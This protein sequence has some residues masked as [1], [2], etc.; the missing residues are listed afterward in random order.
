MIQLSIDLVQKSVI[1]IFL[2]IRLFVIFI[3]M[4]ILIKNGKHCQTVTLNC[5]FTDNHADEPLFS[6]HVYLDFVSTGSKPQF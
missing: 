2:Q 6:V 1:R 5:I 3:I 4:S